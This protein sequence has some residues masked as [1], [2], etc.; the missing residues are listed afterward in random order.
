MLTA[1]CI[2][3]IA[4]KLAEHRDTKLAP[5]VRTLFSLAKQVEFLEE[6]ESISDSRI[7][8]LR[9]IDDNSKEELTLLRGKLQEE[10]ESNIEL[11]KQ[12]SMLKE[13]LINSDLK[14]SVE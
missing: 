3:D 10:H 4:V 8:L 14:L 11:R 7:Q 6:R 1:E 13:A 9:T 2:K 5:V 12:V